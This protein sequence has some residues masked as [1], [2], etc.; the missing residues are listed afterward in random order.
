MVDAPNRADFAHGTPRRMNWAQ[1]SSEVLVQQMPNCVEQFIA[2]LACARLGIVATPVQVQYREYE[3]A[4]ILAHAQAVAVVTFARIGT[5]AAGHAAAAMYVELQRTQP[6][7]R[8]VIAFGAGGP[9]GCVDASATPAPT[10]A[11][12]STLD[13]R[14]LGANVSANDVFTICWTSGTEAQPKGVPRSH[15]EWLVIVPSIVQAVETR[16]GARLLKPYSLVSMAGIDF[17]RLSRIGSGSAPLS[18]W[19][20][21]GF[22]EKHGVQIVNYFGSN[23]ARHS[24][25]RRATSLTRP[26]ALS[27]YRARASAVSS[28][29]YR[30]R[31]RSV[32]ASSIWKPVSTSPK[33]ATLASCASRGRRSSAAMTVR[34]R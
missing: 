2:Y 10:D 23:E 26:C 20:V 21:R 34:P 18:D 31:K 14:T 3:T 5:A 12:R 33:P 32:P 17:K 7:L 4:H 15:N 1:L 19:T 28:G 11:Q 6:S 25:A 30:P 24:P 22:A 29:R 13:T 9:A 27:S 16:P 8:R